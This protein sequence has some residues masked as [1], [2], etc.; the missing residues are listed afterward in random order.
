VGSNL[1]TALA[2]GQAWLTS[3]AKL[4]RL[5]AL[6]VGRRLRQEA[7]AFL[8]AWQTRPW[9]IRFIPFEQGQF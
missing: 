1:M 6:S 5:I 4:R 3:D 9:E 2:G 7:K 8:R